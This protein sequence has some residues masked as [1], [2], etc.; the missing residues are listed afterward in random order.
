MGEVADPWRCPVDMHV[1][2]TSDGAI[3]GVETGGHVAPDFAA[4]TEE[5]MIVDR[6][7]TI[8][9]TDHVETSR[10]GCTGIVTEVEGRAHPRVVTERNGA[11]SGTAGPADGP[12]GTRRLTPCTCRPAADG[13]PRRGPEPT[14][15]PVLDPSQ[16]APCL[17]A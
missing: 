14:I 17:R 11:W 2:A 3:P 16:S 12:D 8:L 9:R 7:G 13:D 15:G 10:I 5:G 4:G 6:V 1:T